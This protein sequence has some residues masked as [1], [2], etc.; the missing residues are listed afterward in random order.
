MAREIAVLAIKVTAN[1]AEVKAAFAKIEDDANKAA[2][3]FSALGAKAVAVG[4]IISSAFEKAA[5]YVASAIGLIVREW[6]RGVELSGKYNA[7]MTGLISV[8]R[9]FGISSDAAQQA[10]R[11]L[12]QDG[13]LPLGDS[14]AGLKNLLMT[15]FG[16]KQAED[17]MN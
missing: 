15:G 8:S 12:S 11:R 3:S 4:N 16:L 7:A 14:A 17:I 9:A 6:L 5:S 13:L 2:T 1:T 10:A